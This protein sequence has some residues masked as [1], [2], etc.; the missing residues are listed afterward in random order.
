MIRAP[1]K[2]KTTP[3]SSPK[4]TPKTDRATSMTRSLGSASVNSL[5]LNECDSNVYAEI[6]VNTALSTNTNN[7]NAIID[8][9]D[10]DTNNEIESTV[11][12]SIPSL[13][14]LDLTEMNSSRTNLFNV[15]DEDQA[16][17]DI[18][19][20]EEESAT[21]ARGSSEV[22]ASEEEQI[23]KKNEEEIIEE[24]VIRRHNNDVIEF[25]ED[26]GYKILKKSTLPYAN[27]EIADHLKMAAASNLYDIDVNAEGRSRG[28]IKKSENKSNNNDGR[29]P[30]QAF[31]FAAKS[32]NTLFTSLKD[33]MKKP[34]A[35]PF[36]MPEANE[37]PSTDT[38]S[39]SWIAAGDAIQSVSSSTAIVVGDKVNDSPRKSRFKQKL[40]FGFKFA[41]SKKPKMCQRC[42]KNQN[43]TPPKKSINRAK[44]T[45]AHDSIDNNTY[46][47]CAVDF[48]DDGS[49]GTDHYSELI[50]VSISLLSVLFA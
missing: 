26:G 3:T 29:R 41:A 47:T 42:L 8:S 9:A 5:D 19:E 31:G 25:I 11:F 4:G 24:V 10:T 15:D 6:D 16:G 40:K 18:K 2:R 43:S 33:R 13:N 39:P 1:F 44:E 35:N 38:G 23:D 7:T 49:R 36:E 37:P 21:N 22:V 27:Q 48:G 46:C 28:A 50:S 12:D 34:A 32:V 30:A 17:A 14:F 20:P 45:S